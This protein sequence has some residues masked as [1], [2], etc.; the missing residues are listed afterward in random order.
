MEPM[1]LS[2]SPTSM[3]KAV[4]DIFDLRIRQAQYLKGCHREEGINLFSIA[5]E[6]RI[7]T[8]GWKLITGRSNLKLRRNFLMVRTIK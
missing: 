5:P 8:N 3:E 4:M 7:R 1:Y 2:I 6:G